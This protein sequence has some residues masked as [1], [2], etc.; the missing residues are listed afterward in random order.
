[1]EKKIWCCLLFKEK[2]FADVFVQV[3]LK[4][5]PRYCTLERWLEAKKKWKEGKGIFFV[6][7]AQNHAKPLP[8]PPGSS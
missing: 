8:I 4:Q 3:A 7:R 6:Q 1:M 2:L 5:L